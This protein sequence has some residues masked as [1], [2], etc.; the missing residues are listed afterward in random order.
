V[1][2]EYDSVMAQIERHPGV[3]AAMLVGMDD[4]MV[5][6]GTDAPGRSWEPAAALASSL[7]RK[8]REA[9]TD[10]GLGG[11]TFVRLEADRGYVCATA[12]GE[13]VLVA[14]TNRSINL[15]RLRLEM[16]SAAEQL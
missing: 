11:A 13:M 14:V 1:I 4:G 10:A 3:L 5:I 16:L 7:F 15:G 2:S 12:R 9:A 8:T 6:S